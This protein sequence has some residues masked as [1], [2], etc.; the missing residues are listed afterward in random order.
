M[1][2]AGCS[3]SNNEIG[4]MHIASVDVVLVESY[5]VRVGLNIKGELS[6]PCVELHSITQT[7]KGDQITVSI[8]TSRPRDVRCPAVAVPRAI[9]VLLDGEI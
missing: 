5:P 9:S 3:Q 1:L 4:E 2:L 8:L 7:R 6:D